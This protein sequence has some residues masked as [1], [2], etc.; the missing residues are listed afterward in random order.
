MPDPAAADGTPAEIAVAF[1]DTYRMLNNRISIFLSLPLTKLD[2]LSLQKRLN[3]I[4]KT[5]DA[6]MKSTPAPRISERRPIRSLSRAVNRAGPV[7]RRRTFAPL[8]AC[9]TTQ[10]RM[11]GW[12]GTTDAHLL[13]AW[14]APDR[15]AKAGGGIMAHPSGPA[16]GVRSLQTWWRAAVEVGLDEA[17]HGDLLLHADHRIVVAGHAG[18]A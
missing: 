11:D 4:G 18:I 16:A 15:K 14:G 7:A 12:V 3:A 13:S 17:L 2:T 6:P 10:E 1:A 5:E 9:A 8:G